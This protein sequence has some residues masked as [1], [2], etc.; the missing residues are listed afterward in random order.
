MHNLAMFFIVVLECSLDLVRSVSLGIYYDGFVLLCV[1]F[2]VYIYIHVTVHHGTQ[3][4]CIIICS[5]LIENMLAFLQRIF[6]VSYVCDICF[7]FI[8]YTVVQSDCHS[9]LT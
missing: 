6:L 7:Y 9:P 4:D 3:S 5:V 1:L 8:Q 2:Y